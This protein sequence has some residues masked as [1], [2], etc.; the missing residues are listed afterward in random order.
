MKSESKDLT[1][2]LP[3]LI[4]QG[5]D[6]VEFHA[7]VDD[8]KEIFEKWKD[9]ND[10][11]SGLV[12]I[13]TDRS[14]LGND[15]LLQRTVRMLD[16]KKPYSVIIQADG[17]PMSGGEDDYRTTLQSIAAAEVFEKANLPVYLL[18]SGGTNSK[19]T[20]LAKMCGIEISGVA[21]GSFARKI[22]AQYIDRTDFW[23]NKEIFE[24][25]LVVAKN[26]VETS[27]KYL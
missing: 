13:C 23:D 7:I 18:V 15:A 26:L 3:P 6:C 19:T 16:G 1:E 24:K 2:I 14:K 12:S 10:C 8:D 11:Y 5:I 4:K 17:A 21:I 27:L 22:V 25:A 20:E 9:I